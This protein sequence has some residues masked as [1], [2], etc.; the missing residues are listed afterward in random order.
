MIKHA[1]VKVFGEDNVD[2][3]L[4]GQMTNNGGGGTGLLFHRTLEDKGITVNS[5]I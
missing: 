4:H 5:E 2:C 1:S 3:I